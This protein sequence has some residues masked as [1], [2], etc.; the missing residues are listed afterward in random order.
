MDNYENYPFHTKFDDVKV[1]Y[2]DGKFATT[3][4]NMIKEKFENL[5]VI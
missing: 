4:E 3:F 2:F 5:D 1:Q